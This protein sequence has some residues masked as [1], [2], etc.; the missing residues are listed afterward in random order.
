VRIL[1]ELGLARYEDRAASALAGAR[2]SLERSAA[3][4]AYLGRLAECERYLA[5]EAA[6][7]PASREPAAAASA[8][9]GD[10]AASV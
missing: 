2:T 5:A 8:A 3:H 10:A 4:R 7:W 1:V 9:A 6:R